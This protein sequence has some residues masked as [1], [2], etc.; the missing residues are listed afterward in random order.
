MVA[1]GL[2]AEATA[3]RRRTRTSLAPVLRGRL[4]PPPRA[5]EPLRPGRS[6]VLSPC[7]QCEKNTARVAAST[8]ASRWEAMLAHVATF[9]LTVSTSESDPLAGPDTFGSYHHAARAVRVRPG[10]DRAEVAA[11]LAHELAHAVTHDACSGM[12]RDVCDVIAESVADA[13]CS[14]FG[15]DLSLRSVA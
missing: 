2:G 10:R 13:V 7:A 14:R 11:T 5:N 3:V 6:R 15:L 12:P 4:A 9:N 1:G 8:M